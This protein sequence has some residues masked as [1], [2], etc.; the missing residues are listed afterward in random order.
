MFRFLRS[1]YLR[2]WLRH[3]ALRKG[4]L[5]RPGPWM[6]VFFASM[7]LRQFKKVLKRGVMPIRFSEK[8]EPG[9]TYVISHIVQPSRRERRKASRSGV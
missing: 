4:L 7:V 5:G 8:L 1:G 2:R 6:F 3:N 9:A